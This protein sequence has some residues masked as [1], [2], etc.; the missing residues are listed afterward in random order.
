[1]ANDSNSN[2][3]RNPLRGGNFSLEGG[4]VL[5]LGGCNFGSKGVHYSTRGDS[6]KPQRR[7]SALRTKSWTGNCQISPNFRLYSIGLKP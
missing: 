2:F 7:D 6:N 4:A 1:M 3:D 5:N